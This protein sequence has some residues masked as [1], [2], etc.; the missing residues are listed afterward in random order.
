MNI[1]VTTID[2]SVQSFG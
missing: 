2:C 1:F